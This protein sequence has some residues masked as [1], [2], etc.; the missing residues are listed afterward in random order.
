MPSPLWVSIF[1]AF[2]FGKYSSRVF[3]AMPEM[4][5]MNGRKDCVP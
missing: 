1:V 5:E 4:R 2:N 3:H